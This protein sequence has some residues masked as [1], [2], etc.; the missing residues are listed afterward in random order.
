M[1]HG[2]DCGTSICSYIQRYVGLI[3]SPSMFGPGFAAGL[4]L[5]SDSHPHASHFV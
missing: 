4:S 5:S 3:W 2:N 1:N